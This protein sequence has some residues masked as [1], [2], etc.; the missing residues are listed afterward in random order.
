MPGATRLY[1][2]SLRIISTDGHA[3]SKGGESR[4]K[5]EEFF[6]LFQLLYKFDVSYLQKYHK[7]TLRSQPQQNLTDQK[8]GQ[9]E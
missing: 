8:E 4:V 5:Q 7:S 6:V 2:A 3:K 9:C 1:L